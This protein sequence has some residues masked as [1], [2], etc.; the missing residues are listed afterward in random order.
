MRYCMFGLIGHASGMPPIPTVE[1]LRD[2]QEYSS[3]AH[4]QNAVASERDSARERARFYAAI[5]CVDPE[6]GEVIV[7][8]YHSLPSL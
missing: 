1:F 2:A 6:D 7:T 4:L 5:L 8:A 3:V